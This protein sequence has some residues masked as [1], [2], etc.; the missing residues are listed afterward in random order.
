MNK[1]SYQVSDLIAN[2]NQICLQK[3]TSQEMYYKN[4]AHIDPY[5]Y[6][7]INSNVHNYMVSK[8]NNFYFDHTTSGINTTL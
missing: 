3:R 5:K 6:K 7:Y 4:G 2:D 8:T 1:I